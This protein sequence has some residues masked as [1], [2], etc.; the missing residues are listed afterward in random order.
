MG[1][2]PK[3]MHGSSTHI[4][5]MH[6][7]GGHVDEVM[8]HVHHKEEGMKAQSKP[9]RAYMACIVGMTHGKVD[10]GIGP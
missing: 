2:V 5:D 3:G 6:G 1:R 4:D 7:Y 9:R 10:K 8:E